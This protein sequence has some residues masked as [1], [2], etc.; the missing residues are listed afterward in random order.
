MSSEPTLSS[1]D[2]KLTMFLESQKAVNESNS[3][4]LDKLS[5]ALAKSEA[6]QV[7]F[8]AQSQRV[9]EISHKMST[10]DDKVSNL[11]E[12]VAINKILVGQTQDLK[13]MFAKSMVGIFV[14]F[15]LSIG[16]AVYGAYAKQESDS[17][18]ADQLKTVLAEVL[19]KK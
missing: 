6:L 13:N 9:T 4:T 3:K 5:T 11:S 12:Q 7:E 14:M 2:T 17:Q 16:S 15:L 8:N 10:M 19:A 18:S 1:I